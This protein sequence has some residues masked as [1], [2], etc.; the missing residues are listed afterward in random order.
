MPKPTQ[1]EMHISYVSE[2]EPRELSSFFASNFECRSCSLFLF[3]ADGTHNPCLPLLFFCFPHSPHVDQRPTSGHAESGASA[4]QKRSG[5]EDSYSKNIV[6]G[7]PFIVEDWMCGGEE[8][9][10]SRVLKENC[11]FCKRCSSFF[12]L[13]NSRQRDVCS[14]FP[15]YK[16]QNF[17]IRNQVPGA[18]ICSE[19]WPFIAI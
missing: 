9:N 7:H 12:F 2:R 18:F 8:V 14:K 4:Q 17:S 3:V 11:H 6:S 16:I 15:S 13:K 10:L 19:L 5:D 1:F